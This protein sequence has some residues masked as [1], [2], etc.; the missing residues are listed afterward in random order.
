MQKS[1]ALQPK[2]FFN[3][4]KKINIF[5]FINEIFITWKIQK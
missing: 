3:N 2:I 4:K 5:N 1:S